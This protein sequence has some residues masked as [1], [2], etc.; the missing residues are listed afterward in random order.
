MTAPEV[1]AVE[2]VAQMRAVA[3]ALLPGDEASPSAAALPDMDELLQHAASALGGHIRALKRYIRL[4]PNECD[5]STLARFAEAEPTAFELISVV[6]AGAYFMSPTVLGSIGY[7]SGGRTAP[8]FDQAADEI[9]SGILEPVL[10]RGRRVRQIS[11]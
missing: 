10:A 2:E 3:A 9:A 1:L 5:W 8:R 4:L 7:P 6:A 11:E